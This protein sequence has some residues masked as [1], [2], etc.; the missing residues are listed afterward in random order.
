MAEAEVDRVAALM[1]AAGMTAKIS[2]IH[3]NGWFGDYGKL[4]ITRTLMQERYGVDLARAAAS[5][6]AVQT[7]E[8]APVVAARSH[9]PRR[10]RLAQ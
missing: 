2:P 1:R 4:G 7:P 3:V 8:D 5:A 10:G 6:V 9:R